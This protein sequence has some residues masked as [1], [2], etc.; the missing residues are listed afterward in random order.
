MADPVAVSAIGIN[1]IIKWSIIPVAFVSAA[2]TAVFIGVIS[3][4]CLGRDE[5]L[6]DSSHK[7]FGLAFFLMFLCFPV[8]DF[9]FRAYKLKAR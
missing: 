4:G 7:P 9:Y 8:F 5:L 2:R 1:I 3:T 6:L